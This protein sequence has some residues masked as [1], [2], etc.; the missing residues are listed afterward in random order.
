MDKFYDEAGV[1]NMYANILLGNDLEQKAEE[2]Y[3]KAVSAILK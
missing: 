1:Y 3:T 2:Y